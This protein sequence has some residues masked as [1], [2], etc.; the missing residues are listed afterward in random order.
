MGR[1]NRR[2]S[3]VLLLILLLLGHCSLLLPLYVLVLCLVSSFCDVVQ[4]VFCIVQCVV[5]VLPSSR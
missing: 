5:C 3:E 4:C 2:L 1:L